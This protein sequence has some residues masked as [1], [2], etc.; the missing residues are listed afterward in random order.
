MFA[1]FKLHVLCG[2]V[3]PVGL[4]TLGYNSTLGCR[5]TNISYEWSLDNQNS[6][7]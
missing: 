6:M 4:Q 3:L 5:W 1:V 2:A 7:A